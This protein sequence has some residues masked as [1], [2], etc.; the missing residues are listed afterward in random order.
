MLSGAAVVLATLAVVL[1]MISQAH[2]GVTEWSCAVEGVGVDY[3]GVGGG[4]WGFDAGLLQVTDVAQFVVQ[5]G[6]LAASANAPCS[7]QAFT[8]Y[9]VPFTGLLPLV[10]SLA[11]RKRFFF[12]P[13]R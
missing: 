5:S 9:F 3:G 7:L 10:S 12:S 1:T 11:S 8:T 4:V 2:V 6:Q 13:C